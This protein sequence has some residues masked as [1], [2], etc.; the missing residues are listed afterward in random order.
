[1][2]RNKTLLILL[3]GIILGACNLPFSGSTAKPSISPNALTPALTEGTPTGP[4]STPQSILTKPVSALLKLND[5]TNCRAG[6]GTNYEKITVIPEGASVSVLARSTEGTHFLVDPPDNIASCW[7]LAE[8]GTFSGEIASVPQATSSADENAGAPARP[9]SLYYTYECSYGAPQ[10]VT[11]TLS[12]GDK[13]NNENGYR[14]YRDGE[15]I[16]ELPA[17]SSQY[18]DETNLGV[19]DTLTYSVEAFNDAGISPQQTISFS[20][21]G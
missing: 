21:S 19:G 18:A 11:T 1:M 2:K 17:N 20:C 15:L 6:P 14:V 10:G 7:V 12:W 16:I 3:G 9:S 13:A 5:N 8:L 4:S